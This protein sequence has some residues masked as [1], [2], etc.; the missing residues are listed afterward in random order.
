MR[1]V[2]ETDLN[3]AVQSVQPVQDVDAER[4]SPPDS[5]KNCCPSR[6]IEID[7]ARATPTES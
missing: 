5:K 3:L 6:Q 7:Q 2:F 1:M 4:V